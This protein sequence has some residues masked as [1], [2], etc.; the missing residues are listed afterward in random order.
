MGFEFSLTHLGINLRLFGHLGDDFGNALD[1]LFVTLPS[2][3][4]FLNIEKSFPGQ[5]PLN[6]VDELKPVD[7]LREVANY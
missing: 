3:S 7:E 6:E 4:T 5:V 2:S 1:F